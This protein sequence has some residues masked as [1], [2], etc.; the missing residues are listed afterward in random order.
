M[1]VF[2]FRLQQLHANPEQ[3]N[4][5]DNLE[6]RNGQQSQGEGNQDHPQDDG[7]CSA[8]NNASG[9]QLVRQVSAGQGNHHRIVTTQQD[10][11]HDDLANR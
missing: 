3:Q 1:I 4:G 11:N 9:T 7:P 2:G 6:V 5:P 10:V 8:I